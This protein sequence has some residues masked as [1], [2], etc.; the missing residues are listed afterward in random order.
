MKKIFMLLLGLLMFS[1]V[2]CAA[3][4]Q[5]VDAVVV[6]TFVVELSDAGREKIKTWSQG[7]KEFAALLTESEIKLEEFGK[8]VMQDALAVPLGNRVEKRQPQQS[9]LVL[10]TGSRDVLIGGAD[11]G[12]RLNV[13][14]AA[15]EGN[16]ITLFTDVVLLANGEA[17]EKSKVSVPA[18]KGQYLSLSL[19]LPLGGGYIA[20]GFQKFGGLADEDFHDCIVIQTTA[21]FVPQQQQEQQSAPAPEGD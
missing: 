20:G 9:P 17:Q 5:E 19:A 7:K 1:A 21:R 8:L 10:K 2:A 11:N 15:H 12:A 16:N 4:A 14:Y 13:E 6:Q 18:I 3:P